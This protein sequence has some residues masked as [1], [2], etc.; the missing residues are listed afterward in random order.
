MRL[1]KSLL[2]LLCMSSLAWADSKSESPAEVP[3]TPRVEKSFAHKA[4]MFLPNRIFDLVD[5]L[6]FR[7]RFGPGLAVNARATE[8]L[9]VYAGSYKTV[10]IGLPGPRE[11]AALRKPF[12]R[13]DQKGLKLVGVD[14]TDDTPYD[15][16]YS[17]SEFNVG[18]QLLI[19]GAEIGMDPVQIGDFLAGWIGRDPRGDDR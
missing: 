19:V 7:V 4:V 3:A 14:A 12:G 10:Y 18:A 2:A 17:K 1:T 8:L 9:D 11:G 16:G 6:R 13:E 15:P 5:I